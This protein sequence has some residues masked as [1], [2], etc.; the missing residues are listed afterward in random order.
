MPLNFRTF[1]YS[2]A[3]HSE[4]S[5]EFVA[6]VSFLEQTLRLRSVVYAIEF[7]TMYGVKGLLFADVQQQ[8]LRFAQND[9]DSIFCINYSCDKRKS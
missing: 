8:T 7:V 9:S 4:R 1:A 2:R 3:C 5:E 6:L